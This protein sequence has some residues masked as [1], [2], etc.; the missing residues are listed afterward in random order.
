M[1][2]C[3][4]GAAS[5]RCSLCAV[6]CCQGPPTVHCTAVNGWS[7]V[8]RGIG[9]IRTVV[10]KAKLGPKSRC[11]LRI[12]QAT[13][14]QRCLMCRKPFTEHKPVAVCSSSLPQQGQSACPVLCSTTSDVCKGV[15]CRQCH[16]QA[17]V[18]RRIRAKL[19]IHVLQLHSSA[20]GKCRLQTS[21]TQWM[22]MITLGM[23]FMSSSSGRSWAAPGCFWA[24]LGS[25]GMT[26][27]S[28]SSMLRSCC[29]SISMWDPVGWENSR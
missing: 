9:C 29:V 18:R 23:A 2:G 26:L 5:G 14:P 24:V 6:S 11:K 16:M 22:L 15:H 10:A 17:H 19:A 7:A 20:Y 4:N 21:D 3:I 28:A 13:T 25:A 8:L 12:K 27:G 1:H